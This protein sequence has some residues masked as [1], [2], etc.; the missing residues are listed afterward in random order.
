[1]RLPWPVATLLRS[2]YLKGPPFCS[3]LFM[4]GLNHVRVLEES[5]A[6]TRRECGHEPSPN[7]GRRDGVDSD[8]R[9]RPLVRNGPVQSGSSQ[10]PGKRQTVDRGADCSPEALVLDPSGL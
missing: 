1:M 10:T 7:D 2:Q 9:L 4:P 8:T 5:E 3:N 6:D